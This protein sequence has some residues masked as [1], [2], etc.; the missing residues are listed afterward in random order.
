MKTT[1]KHSPPQRWRMWTIHLLQNR[2]FL[3]V[4]NTKKPTMLETR[5]V[6]GF[7]AQH[8]SVL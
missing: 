1:L 8:L 5:K 7:V 6:S 4:A 3:F 2:T